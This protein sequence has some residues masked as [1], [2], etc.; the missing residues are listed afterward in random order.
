MDKK[1]EL[2]KDEDGFYRVRALE[3]IECSI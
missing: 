3:V 1:Y 2:I